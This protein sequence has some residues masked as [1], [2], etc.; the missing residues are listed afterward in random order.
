MQSDLD[1]SCDRL[2]IKFLMYDIDP[3][4]GEIAESALPDFSKHYFCIS[5]DEGIISGYTGFSKEFKF[6]L[7]DTNDSISFKMELKWK[8]NPENYHNMKLN[9]SLVLSRLS[10]TLL[11]LGNYYW[12]FCKNFYRA[13]TM[14]V[15]PTLRTIGKK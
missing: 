12:T 6:L 11:Y 7:P 14:S 2:Y 4:D 9:P 15:D 10:G 3:Q 1:L 13:M 8:I 5:L